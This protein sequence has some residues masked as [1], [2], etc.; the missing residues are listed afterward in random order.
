MRHRRVAEHALDV[1]LGDR[2]H[3]PDDHGQDRDGPQH[4]PPLVLERRHGDVEQA[5][6]R[7]ER[8]GL[9]GGRHERDDGGGRALVHIGYPR[10]ERH[11]ADLEQQGDS[12]QGG[13]EEGQ[14]GVLRTGSNRFSDTGEAQS[15]GVAVQQR[16]AVEEERRRERPQQKVFQRR[17]LGEQSPVPGQAAHQV[18]RQREHLERDEHGEQIV[19]GRKQHHAADGEHGQREHLGLGDPGLDGC[20]FGE[21]ARNRGCLRGERVQSRCDPPRR[22]RTVRIGFAATFGD[23]QH[24]DDREPHD[25]ALQQQRGP[26]DGDRSHGGQLSGAGTDGAVV[27]HHGDESRDQPDQGERDL[28]AVPAPVRCEGLH[29]HTG[30]RDD[31]HDQHR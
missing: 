16:H 29:Q 23:Q 30:H 9:G 12:H 14:C 8:G 7:A 6:Q 11:R 2:G 18:Q 10:S 27:A 1:A 31:E 24:A 19:G 28:D 3:R 15:A 21:A 20:L 4:R 25:G 17:L 5:Q 26:V 22:T 13:A